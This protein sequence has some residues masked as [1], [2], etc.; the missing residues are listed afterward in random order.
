MFYYNL[1]SKIETLIYWLFIKRNIKTSIAVIIGMQIIAC[2]ISTSA[3]SMQ[4]S[5]GKFL[6][7]VQER[8]VAN[9]N[10]SEQNRKHE[11]LETRGATTMESA[12]YN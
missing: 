7:I 8:L 12:C 10:L 11:H 4:K 2:P 6:E 5:V 3:L 1:N 9:P